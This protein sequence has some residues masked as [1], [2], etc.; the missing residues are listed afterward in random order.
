MPELSEEIRGVTAESFARVYASFARAC[1]TLF[2]E[3]AYVQIATVPISSGV[4]PTVRFVGSHISV[5][6]PYVVQALTLPQ[7]GVFM[8]QQCVRTH[9]LASVFDN[10]HVPRWGS[11][12]PSLGVVAHPAHL[13]QLQ[14]H[15]RRFF[16]RA[17]GAFGDE[18]LLRISS[19]DEDLLEAARTWDG[20]TIEV[21]TRHAG[22]Y[23]HQL[24]LDGVAGRSFNIAL[25]HGTS[26]LFDDVGNVILI[27]ADRE[28]RG[29]ELALGVTTMFRQRSAASHVLDLSPAHGLFAGPEVAVRKLEDAIMTSIVLY[30]DGV[31]P[32]SD[33]RGRLL[34]A[35]LRSMLYNAY[36]LGLTSASLERPLVVAESH[37]PYRSDVSVAHDIGKDIQTLE[38]RIRDGSASSA[39]D[40]RVAEALNA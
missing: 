2:P 39:A 11:T 10:N 28:P 30:R 31:R 26:D 18:I 12:F 16:E 3:L 8:L 32:T 37:E 25:R 27:E 24:G 40:V 36:R 33:N 13:E 22:Y 20:S 15:A 35:Y 9:N 5:L 14:V 38:S 6:K 29:I 1:E 4:D 19:A 7:P 34:R 23:R 21:D 17:L